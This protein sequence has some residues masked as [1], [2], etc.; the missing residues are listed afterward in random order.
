MGL[1][2]EYSLGHDISQFFPQY[3]AS[4]LLGQTEIII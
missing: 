4:E 2:P 1:T 3:F